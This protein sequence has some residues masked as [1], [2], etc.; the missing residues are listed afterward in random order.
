[1][2]DRPQ[3]K[4]YWMMT[5]QVFDLAKLLDS[6]LEDI[7]IGLVKQFLLLLTKQENISSRSLEKK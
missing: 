3:S 5:K 2:D 4:N 1:M 7:I 6:D